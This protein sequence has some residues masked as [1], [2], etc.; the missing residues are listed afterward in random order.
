MRKAEVQ[1]TLKKGAEEAVAPPSPLIPPKR[2]KSSSDQVV[3]GSLGP[4]SLSG[5]SA[6]VFTRKMRNAA[7]GTGCDIRLKVS[8]SGDPQPSLYWYHNEE[9]LNMENQEYGGLWI[10]D[11]KPSDAGLYTCIANNHQG[12]ARSSAVLAVLD[13]GEE[14]ESE[15]EEGEEEEERPDS[16]MDTTA[17]TSRH[18]DYSQTTRDSPPQV[19]PPPSPRLSKR[20]SSSPMP[21]R[22]GSTTPIGSRKKNIP[23]TTDYQDTVPGEFEEKVRHPKSA[24]Q[25]TANAQD[26][27]P[28]T[29]LS[30]YSRKEF[31]PRPSPKLTRASSKVFEKVRGLEERRRSLD[32]PEGSVSGR[33]WAGFNRVG[34]VDSD[35]G[36]SRLGISRESSREDLR[37]ALKEDAAERRSMFRQ[38]AASL[39]DKPRYS[40][41][42][43]D[44][45]NKFTE[46][47]QRIKKLVGKPHMKKSFSTEQ[48]T[49]KAKQRQPF[50]KIE[51]IPPQV[52]QKLQE[53]ERAQWAKE[54][55]E[56]EL[57]EQK[58]QISANIIGSRLGE[59][60]GPP[61][62]MQ[63]ADLPGQR[64]LRELS[65][66]SPVTEIVQRSSS[67]LVHQLESYRKVEKRPASPLVQRVTRFSESNHEKED[68]TGRKTPIEVALRKVELR[69]ESPLVQRRGAESNVLA[70]PKPPRVCAEER[71]E[72][73]SV[74]RIVVQEEDEERMEVEERATPQTTGGREGAPKS[75]K[76]KIRPMSPEQDSSDDSYVSAGEDP[77]EA[78]IFEFPLQDAVA[79]TGADVVL[80]CIIA[81]TPT[82]EV[83]WTKDSGPVSGLSLN[84]TVKVEGERHSLWIRSVRT[85]NAGV[86]CVTASNQ[87]GT[88]S[89]SATLT[90]KENVPVPRSNLGLPLDMSS[91]ITSDEEYLSPL[92]ENPEPVTGR[93]DPRFRQPPA[94]V[95]TVSDQTVVE[96]QEV[97]MS[98]R[99]SGQPKPMLYWLRDRVTVKS[100]PRHVVR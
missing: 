33:S 21:S 38:R 51:P 48:L 24:T 39:E 66:V 19:L 18:E 64:P 77:M 50:R 73:R 87:V 88:A 98:V 2:S 15:E 90:V 83:S 91:P 22:S 29:P 71:A 16:V 28:Q 27:R 60:P 96:G 5:P 74:P 81:G 99:I 100:G 57:H 55:K 52:L 20:L 46:E 68:V 76:K 78:P 61:E 42:V 6:P 1:V 9:L 36:W 54:Q 67:P 89:S 56:R 65:R 85:S 45:E 30:D 12:E 72:G 41:K 97:S 75:R 3:P 53:R 47:L 79:F 4:Q 63:L 25:T 58:P 49:L 23:P 8:V 80:K 62:S 14:S 82:P 70:P 94:F 92:E 69:P 31:T 59:V 17:D 26:T 34:S 32:I 10:R 43:Q 11:C 7:V 86:Y 40:Q 95:A 84:Y 35:D 37:E 44:I 13:L 93:L